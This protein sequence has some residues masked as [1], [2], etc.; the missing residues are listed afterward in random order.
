LPAAT[1]GGTQAVFATGYDADGRSSGSLDALRRASQITYNARGEV[2]SL[3]EP[4]V[5]GAYPTTL[6]SYTADGL[7]QTVTDPLGRVTSFSYDTGGRLLSQTEPDPDGAGALL[8]STQSFVYDALGNVLASVD[9]LGHTTRTSYDAR[10][11]AVSLVDPASYQTTS[12]FDVFGNLV[13]VTDAKANTTSYTYDRW[14]RGYVET[15]GTSSRTTLLDGLGNL[16]QATD[17]NGRVSTF[18]YDH[19]YQL[20]REVWKN[21]SNQEIR[22]FVYTYDTVGNL[23][24]VADNT[25]NPSNGARTT[26]S[27]A[28]QFVYD[29]RDQL[30]L[31]RAV[32]PLVA[33]STVL[34]HDYDLN[35]RATALA[36]NL[37]GT[38]SG[39]NIT[40]G[41][42]DLTNQYVSDA[43][44]RLTSV[45]QTSQYGGN[46]VAAKLATFQYDAASELTDLR[47]YSSTSAYSM[48]LEVH[49]RLGYDG[50]GRL[51]SLTH[52]KS[53]I[54]AGQMW[55]GTSTLPTSLQGGKLLAGYFLAYDQ[56]NRLTGWSSYADAFKTTYA[57]DTRDQ[58]T[59]ASH[60]AIAGLTLPRAMPASETYA[61]DGTGN[62]NL[63]G[64]SSSSADGTFNRVQNDGTYTYDFDAEGNQIRRTK[65]SDGKVTEY[66]YDYRNRLVKVTEKNS[67][68]GAATKKWSPTSTDHS[69]RTGV[70]DA[71]WGDEYDHECRCA[72]YDYEHEWEQPKRCA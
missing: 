9:G 4:Y 60:T 57:Y 26:A 52:A 25:I 68:A 31:E 69:K 13:S 5:N 36:T 47:R 62:R 10:F 33:V 41:V 16:R 3:L 17:R 72:A 27:D 38:I 11:R 19:R 34:D 21:S 2:A 64:G 48:Y 8:A 1:S 18:E 35:G 71:L 43:L 63:S 40:G 46:S 28:L 67:L 20:T 59:G 49:S 50:A 66:E 42:E 65:I 39:S 37:G 51:Q 12:A 32:N 14:N 55:N 22:E 58:V 7:P 45:T 44:G 54:A 61:F 24:T 53:E 6:F 29:N 23:L 30:Q 15:Q 70:F 56:D